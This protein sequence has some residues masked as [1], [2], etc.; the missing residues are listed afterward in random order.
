MTTPSFLAR[1]VM[2]AWTGPAS[3]A[4]GLE[5]AAAGLES[6]AAG[7]ESAAGGL[8]DDRRLVDTEDAPQRVADLAE[9][10]LRAHGLEDERHEVVAAARGPVHG[11]ERARR[12]HGVARTPEAIQALR[13]RRA[14]GGIDL[15][16]SAGR[17]LIH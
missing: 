16:E 8:E 5:S 15:E 1:S 14:D 2:P 13:H 10:H 17:R 11:L 9:R 6:A 4:A 7:L 12:G 3:A